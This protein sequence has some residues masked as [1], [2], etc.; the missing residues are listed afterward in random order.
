[1]YAWDIGPGQRGG[2][3]SVKL[4]T[5][6]VPRGAA[7]ELDMLLGVTA[8]AKILSVHPNTLRMWGNQGLLP[9]YRVGSRGDRRFKL[10]DV[11]TF[12]RGCRQGAHAAI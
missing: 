2:E 11:E 1:M 8:V 7:E 3:M 6:G 12:V 10:G 9:M 4:R 5:Y